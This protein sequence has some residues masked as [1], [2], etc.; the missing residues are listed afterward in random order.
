[1]GKLIAIVGN[2]GTGKTTLTQRL[3]ERGSFTA[4]LEQHKERP[5]QEQFSSELKRF[6]LSNQ[7]DYLLFRAEQEIH[8]RQHDIIGVQDGGLDQDFHV[9][10]RLFHNKGFL[11]KEEFQ[12]CERLYAT[13]R[14]LLP[15]PDLFIQLT[16]SKSVLINRRATRKRTLDI[17]ETQDLEE[18]EILMQDWIPKMAASSIIYLD[19]SDDDPSYERIIDGLADRAR[20]ILQKPSGDENS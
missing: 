17:V 16:A 14:Q 2:C 10:T 5:F 20:N 12:L 8:A 4:L 11:D 19:T 18:M 9:F 13:L 7:M 15:P 6:S 1:M 3:C